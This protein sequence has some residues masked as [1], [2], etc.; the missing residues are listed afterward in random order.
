MTMP[1]GRMT[2]SADEAG[3]RGRQAPVAGEEHSLVRRRDGQEIGVRYLLMTQHVM[4]MARHIREG[5]AAASGSDAAGSPRGR[6]AD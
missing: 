6:P 2:A 5:R 3:G 4:E 1:S